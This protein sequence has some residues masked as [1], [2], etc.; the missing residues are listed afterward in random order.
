MIEFRKE[1]CAIDDVVSKSVDVVLFSVGIDC[2]LNRG[3]AYELSLNFTDVRRMV[4]SQNY[5]DRRNL[6]KIV[7]TE[8]DGV[9]FVACFIHKGGYARS[10]DGS[11][12]DYDALSDVLRKVDSEFEGKRIC[13]YLLGHDT[14]DGCGDREKILSLFERLCVNNSYIVFDTQQRDY[15]LYCFRR[16]A[17]LRRKVMEG[18]ISK[19]EYRR[20]RSRVEWER[21]HGVSV[22]MPEDFVYSPKK[23]K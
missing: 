17:E 15:K 4:E 23:K 16:I 3:F 20:D 19:E 8:I 12:V 1:G 5:C 21:I 2:C 7:Y 9:T 11:F 13:T 18:E 22:E 6:G 14:A 10:D